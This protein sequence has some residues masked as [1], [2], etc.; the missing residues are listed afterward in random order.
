MKLRASRSSYLGLGLILSFI[1]PCID[2]IQLGKRNAAPAVVSL[3]IQKRTIENP[4]ERDRVRRQAP[5]T[6]EE[7]LDNEVWLSPC[8]VPGYPA[9]QSSA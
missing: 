1:L 5:Q 9:T 7:T 2:A 4:A 8:I 3:D 6:V